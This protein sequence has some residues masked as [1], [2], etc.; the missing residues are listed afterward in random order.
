MNGDK[1][2]EKK[3]NEY[4]QDVED[5]NQLKVNFKDEFKESDYDNLST[6]KSRRNFLKIMGISL[7]ALPLSSCIKIPVKKALPYIK[8]NSSVT[9]GVPNWYATNCQSCSASCPILVKTREGRPIKIEGNDQSV[10]S[11]GGVCAY[12]QASLLNLYDSKRIQFP[13]IDGLKVDWNQI[14][15]KI[16]GQL[17]SIRKKIVLVTPEINSPTTNQLIK[18]FQDKFKNVEHI[19]YEPYSHSAVLHANKE[20]F[21]IYNYPEYN[22]N[23]TKLIVSFESDFLGTWPNPVKYTKD[24]SKKRDPNLK[25]DMLKHIQFESILTLTGSNADIRHTISPKEKIA[26]LKYILKQLQVILKIELFKLDN[27]SISENL[28][29]HCQKLLTSLIQ[30]KGESVIITGGN[31][32]DEQMITISINYILGNY[33]STISL[34][35]DSERTFV[36]DKQ[37]DNFIKDLRGNRIGGVIFWNVNPLFDYRFPKYIAE[38]IKNVPLKISLALT[39]NETTRS[40]NYVIPTNHFLESWDDL[41]VGQDEYSFNQPVIQPLYGS[42]MFQESIMNWLELT[43]D[44]YLYI[45]NNWH[46]RYYHRQSKIRPFQKFWDRSLHDGVI[47][48]IGQKRSKLK[49]TINKRFKEIIKQEK[50]YYSKLGVTLILYEKVGIKSGKY[51]NNAWL[52]ELPDPITKATWGNYVQLGSSLADDNNIKTGDLL[53]ISK[54]NLELTL[55]ALIQP[56]IA[57]RTISIAVGYE[58]VFSFVEESRGFFDYTV[59]DVLISKLGKTEILAQTQ[60]H[61]SMEGRD[62]VRESNIL[63]YMKNSRA[64]NLI[65]TKLIS[66]WGTHKKDGHQWAMMIDLNKCTGCSACIISCNGENNIPVVG[67]KEVHNRRELHWLRIDRYYKG[68]DENP[69]VVHMPVMCQHCD[70]APCETVCPVMATS[71]SSDGLNQQVYNR[72]IGTRYCAN[73]CP[74]K[75]RRF[76]WFNYARDDE[77]ENMVLN[78]DVV[79]RSRGVMEKCSMCVSRIQEAKLKAK[80]D[81]RKLE[82]QEI[83]LACQQSCPGDAIIFGD[84]NDPDS[85]MAKAVIDP[86]NYKLLEEL[87]VKPRV[88]YLTKIRNKEI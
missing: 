39:P 84:L 19:A 24:Y 4:W 82:D 31:S 51:L 71:Q 46:R 34:S 73:N 48:F 88:G 75:V 5:K 43:G 49:L 61:H 81:G 32:I 60:T 15:K 72:C 70:N 6:E 53:K 33:G 20:A 12:G 44:Y 28:T 78:P 21:G 55:P 14:D 68:D 37:F 54:N 86:R 80:I 25:Q 69:E 85:K 47:S 10:N 65:K 17:K 63:E 35:K 77:N 87:N 8:K 42:R 83:K 27:V 9:P 66:L 2:Q 3:V 64:G 50:D 22:F 26:V 62:I 30:N 59:S 56:G 41:Y 40:C 18:R 52:Q 29:N 67:K 36:D 45:K 1:N 38:Y 13:T 58:D 74:Y 7:S 57:K 23:N 11:Q 76:N 16:K 79:V